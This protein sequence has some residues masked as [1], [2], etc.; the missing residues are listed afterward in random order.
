MNPLVRMATAAAAMS[1][2][3]PMR[4]AGLVADRALNS[5]RDPI[6]QRGDGRLVGDVHALDADV[7]GRDT[8]RPDRPGY[9]RRR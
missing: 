2:A 3:E 8:R 1:S 6:R 5:L 7:P 9:A 4:R